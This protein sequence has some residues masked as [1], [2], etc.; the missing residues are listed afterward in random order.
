MK[1]T[2]IIYGSPEQRTNV[3]IEYDY[4]DVK[5]WYGDHQTIFIVYCRIIDPLPFKPTD[6]ELDI[7]LAIAEAKGEHP[8]NI[9]WECN[10][11]Y[12]VMPVPELDSFEG[13]P[14]MMFI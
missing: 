13:E 6:L 12:N 1:T 11:K 7:S 2:A 8:R 5:K 9:R 10:V 14:V 3:T 4:Y